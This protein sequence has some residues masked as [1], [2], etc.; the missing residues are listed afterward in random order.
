[1]IINIL[2]DIVNDFIIKLYS[3]GIHFYQIIIGMFIF[4]YLVYELVS[5]I[6]MSRRLK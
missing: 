4:N 3:S 5:T 1:M 6:K 2:A